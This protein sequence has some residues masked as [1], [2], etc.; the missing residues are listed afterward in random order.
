MK[1]SSS[2]VALDFQRNAHRALLNVLAD[3]R[4]YTFYCKVGHSRSLSTTA[5]L[6]SML[7]LCKWEDG[8]IPHLFYWCTGLKVQQNDG[9][10]DKKLKS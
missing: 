5:T 3:F 4:S 10:E 1:H 6:K 8:T 7:I 9:K 2:E